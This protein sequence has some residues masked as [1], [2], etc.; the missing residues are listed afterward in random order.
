ME[1]PCTCPPD[2]PL[3]VCKKK[4][5]V[6]CLTKKPVTPSATEITLNPM[7]R[8]TKLRAVEKL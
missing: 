7:A 4:P 1:K 3:C 6:R 8:S 5:I 2:F